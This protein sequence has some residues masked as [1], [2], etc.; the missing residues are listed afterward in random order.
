MTKDRYDTTGNVENEFEPDSNNE[1]LRNFL[2]I[3]SKEEMDRQE[4]FAL[5]DAVERVLTIFD[6]NHKFTAKDICDIH[7]IWL[8]E[9]YAWAGKYRT[10]NL[11]KQNF[12]FATAAYIEPL[13][14]DFEQGVLSKWTPC[15]FHDHATLATALAEVHVELILIHPFREGNGRVSRI[16]ATLMA[17]QAGLPLLYFADLSG[18]NTERY[19]K[20]IQSG[21][22]RDYG[23]MKELFLEIIR[24]SMN[25][26]D[27]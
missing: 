21:M 25:W 3:S 13:M 9:I 6:V 17:L 1:V 19:F 15:L 22:S 16:L 14:R 12:S 24:T 8:G 23:P 27:E 26:S 11:G 7:G 10:V 20:A 2:G 4:A 5:Q 18:R